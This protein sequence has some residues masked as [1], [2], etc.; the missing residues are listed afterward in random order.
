MKILNE[1]MNVEVQIY[2]EWI[3]CYNDVI[4]LFL[5]TIYNACWSDIDMINALSTVE[6]M[7]ESS[8]G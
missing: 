2:N 8:I 3:R 5:T 4:F 7:C 1:S 6:E